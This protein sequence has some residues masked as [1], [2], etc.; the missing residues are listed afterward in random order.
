MAKISKQALFPKTLSYFYWTII[1][2]LQD[3]FLSYYRHRRVQDRIML[4]NSYHFPDYVNFTEIEFSLG[5][6]GI[7]RRLTAK[8]VPS[9]GRFARIRLTSWNARRRCLLFETEMEFLYFSSVYKYFFNINY[10]HI[11]KLLSN[12][13]LLCCEYCIKCNSISDCCRFQRKENE[14]VRTEL[15]KR[16]RNF[17]LK[18]NYH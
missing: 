17:W 4:R 1:F 16:E 5:A 3:I 6:Q 18:V 9:N 8:L 15:E 14:Q 12:L 13:L 11:I 7:S 10:H 2:I